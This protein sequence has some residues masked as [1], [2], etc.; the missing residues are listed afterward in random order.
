MVTKTGPVDVLINNAG[1]FKCVEF[2]ESDTKDHVVK[3]LINNDY[4]FFI[5]T[6]Q[7]SNKKKG[8]DEG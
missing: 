2:S 1:I 3:Y 6:L 7:E 8:H 5:K 4:H